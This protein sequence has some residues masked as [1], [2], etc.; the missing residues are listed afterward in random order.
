[1][2]KRWLSATARTAGFDIYK[3]NRGLSPW[4]NT[5]HDFYPVQPKP[6]WK[7]GSQ[8][9]EHLW[10]VLN[11]NRNEYE[12]FLET[13]GRNSDVLHSINREQRSATGPFWNNT[14]FTALDAAALVNFIGWK[15]PSRYIE[16]GSGNSTNF[17]RFAIDFW[18][19]DTEMLS[20]DP[21]PR[22]EIDQLCPKV[23]RKPLEECDLDV[24]DVLDR[25]DILFFDGSHRIFTNSDVAVFFFEVLPR[26]KRGVIVHIH[27]IFFPNDYPEEWN[28]RLYNEQYLLAAMLMCEKPPFKVIAPIQFICCDDDLA[29]RVK[30]IFA[31][32]SNEI[33]FYYPDSPR[34]PGASFWL[35]IT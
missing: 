30:R 11:E 16:V 22:R 7:K 6:R 26:L 28:N 8:T 18:R 24:F 32:S 31:A 13:L 19:L 15:K 4:S 25:D 29:R 2:L 3:A 27:D 34:K 9:F 10:K 35:E 23:I 20:I 1:M 5:V 14:W 12:G 21:K 17:A 33:P